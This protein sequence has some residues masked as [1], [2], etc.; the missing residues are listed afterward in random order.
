MGCL[1]STGLSHEVWAGAVPAG[2]LAA[3]AGREGLSG[4]AVHRRGC[5]GGPA[6]GQVGPGV[7]HSAASSAALFVY[8]IPVAR[9]SQHTRAFPNCQARS[10]VFLLQH[11]E[12]L[13]ESKKCVTQFSGVE[14]ARNLV[15]CGRSSH[16]ALVLAS[17]RFYGN[18]IRACCTVMEAGLL[19]A[20]MRARLP[21]RPAY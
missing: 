2:A 17:A 9:H 10:G 6:A 1:S 5:A 13:N 8:F 7:G 15:R 11:S 18:R 3:H 21:K 12:V 16:A 14:R 4:G 19:M 20:A